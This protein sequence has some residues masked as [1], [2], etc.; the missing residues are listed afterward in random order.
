MEILRKV[1]LSYLPAREGG[2]PEPLLLPLFAVFL[3]ELEL[4]PCSADAGYDVRKEW[5]DILSGGEKQ[6]VR[7]PSRFPLPLLSALRR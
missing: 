1:H 2:E 7:R 3:A 4:M 5:K 6:R